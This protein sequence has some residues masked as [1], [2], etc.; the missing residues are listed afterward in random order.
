MAKGKASIS[1]SGASMS[2]YDV[3]VEKR[4]QALEA[5]AHPVP[6]EGE[7]GGV[8][9]KVEYIVAAAQRAKATDVGVE[10]KLDILLSALAAL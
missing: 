7:G 2:Q 4:L 9:A 5:V 10:G 1:S 8:D 3:E 6:A